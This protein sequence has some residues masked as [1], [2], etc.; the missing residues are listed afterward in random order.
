MDRKWERETGGELATQRERAREREKERERGKE[1][2]RE[3]WCREL[4]IRQNFLLISTLIK[5]TS[6]F[7]R[8]RVLM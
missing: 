4:I 7:G 6:M 3:H 8:L 2:E 1:R 5:L